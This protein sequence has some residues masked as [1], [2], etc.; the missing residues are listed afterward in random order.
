MNN[1]RPIITIDGPAASGKGSL[2]K[3]IAKDLNLYLMETG[4]YYRIFAYKFRRLSNESD[5]NKKLIV[6][7]IDFHITKADR[8]KL[9]ASDISKLASILAKKKSVR[10]LI[11]I[12]QKNIIINFPEIYNGI[13]LEGRDCGTVIAP[14]AK[15]KFFLFSDLSTRANRRYLQLKKKNSVKFDRIYKELEERDKRDKERKNSPLKVAKDAIKI[16]NTNLSLSE[17]INIVKKIIFST[18]PYLKK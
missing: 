1:K 11:V 9:F 2:S 4:L 18:L 7:N 13:I 10:D 3:V 8:K 6:N 5:V 16:D 14:E 15:I 17:T 12:K